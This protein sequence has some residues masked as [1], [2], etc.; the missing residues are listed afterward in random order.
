MRTFLTLVLGL[1]IT[2]SSVEAA[3]A[4]P[5]ALHIT[6]TQRSVEV[7]W[8]A[9]AGTTLTDLQVILDDLELDSL[10]LPGRVLAV[11]GAI[12]PQ[13]TALESVPFTGTLPIGTTNLPPAT[14]LRV[15][16]VELTP[17]AL[18]RAPLTLLR[19]GRIA[20]APISVFA[21]SPLFAADDGL[22]RMA[23]RLH[24]TLPD[25]ILYDP[26]AASPLGAGLLAANLPPA[27]ATLPTGPVAVVFVTSS[28]LQQISGAALQA[29]GFDLN[30]LDPSRLQLSRAGVGLPLELTGVANGRLTAQSELRFYAPPPGDRWNSADRYLIRIATTPGLRIALRSVAPAAAPLRTTAIEYGSWRAPQIYDS[31]QAGPLGDHFFAADLRTGPGTLPAMLSA[32]LTATLPLATGATN[33]VLRGAAY[34]AGPHTLE[35]RTAGAPVQAHWVGIGN[36]EHTVTLPGAA[37]IELALAPGNAVSGVLPQ[38]ITWERPVRLETGGRGALFAGVSGS[39]RYQLGGAAA[40]QPLYDVSDPQQPVRLT[41][42]SGSIFEDGPTPRRYLLAGPATT[43]NPVVQAFQPAP[44]PQPAAALYIAPA[45]LHTSLAPLIAHRRAQGHTVAVVDPQALYDRW[46]HGQMAPEAIRNF[47]RWARATWPTP[48]QSVTLV[49]DGTYD[50]RDYLGRGSPTL[51]PP[52]LADVDRWLGETACETCYAQLDGDHPL[53]DSLPDLAIGRLPVKSAG[54]LAALV[55]KLIRYETAAGGLDWRSR[56]VLLADNPDSGGDFAVL[57]E[58]AAPLLP[59]GMAVERVYFNPTPLAAAPVIG[60]PDAARARNRTLNALNAGAGLV[61]YSGHS[62]HWQWAT[63]DPA[64]ADGYLLGL[65]DPDGLNNSERLPI[66][67]AMSCLSSG[68][69]QAAFSGTT[70]DERLVLHADGGAAAVWGSTGLGVAYGHE[71]LQRGFL[72]ALSAAQ[73]GR[74]NL[75]ELT[76]ASLRELFTNGGCCQDALRTFA[77]LGDPLTPVRISG[78]ERVYVPLAGR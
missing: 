27:P 40:N 5:P 28:G 15:R 24:V 49:G 2:M 1:V 47:L 55:T 25:A 65:Y 53:D 7:R 11:Y 26:Q 35:V 9:S 36:W 67:L 71:A 44:L 42:L 8:Q 73:P 3:P 75:G 43:F 63:T 31:T 21:F 60:E 68:F 39:W 37:Q 74:A 13:L 6:P 48:P 54:E 32:P 61:I 72:N 46:S 56:A 41:G 19:T 30:T 38:S 58:A 66:V 20:G 64:R 57:A 16:D 18:P 51:I 22:P 50:P 29:A 70:V 59:P 34:T 17:G 23:T 77:L 10:K 14:E 78:A 69:H 62:S 33:L 76:G 52:Y 45:E 4:H 12:T